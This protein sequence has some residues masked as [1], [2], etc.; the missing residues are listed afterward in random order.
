LL[1]Q[2]VE[3][4]VDLACDLDACEAD[5]A[6]AHRRVHVTDAEHPAR[7]PHR[8]EDA[9]TLAVKVVVEVAAVRSCETVRQLGAVG[10]DTDD[11]DHRHRRKAHAVVHA[12]LAVADLEESRYG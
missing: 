1:L 10:R 4:N 5:L 6:V 3:A 2:D 9:R 11:A 8:E 7:L 12:N